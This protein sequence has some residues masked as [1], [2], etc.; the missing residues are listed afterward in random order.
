LLDL[1]EGVAALFEE[2]TQTRREYISPESGFTFFWRTWRCSACGL[3]DGMHRLLGCRAPVLDPFLIKSPRAVRRGNPRREQCP[4]C[5]KCG[6]TAG[7]HKLLGCRWLRPLAV[8]YGDVQETRQ[9]IQACT[10][11]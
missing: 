7:H 4:T 3:P 2:A 5:D 9:T 1:H 10:R 11:P 8:A 6:L